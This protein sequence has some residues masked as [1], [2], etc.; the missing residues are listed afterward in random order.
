[1]VLSQVDP[2][3][4]KGPVKPNRREFFIRMIPL[5]QT[6]RFLDAWDSMT[7]EER[8][9]GVTR[10]YSFPIVIGEYPGAP[11]LFPSEPEP[12]TYH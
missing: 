6:L 8:Q 1:M 12:Q 2:K 5:G 11:Q 7:E 4:Q 10:L 3:G 9:A